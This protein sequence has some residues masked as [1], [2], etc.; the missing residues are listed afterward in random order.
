MCL[1]YNSVNLALS[2]AEKGKTWG[3][4]G[5]TFSDIS[6]STKTPSPKEVGLHINNV[7]RPISKQ[8]CIAE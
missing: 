8:A 4:K 1:L 7:C 6:L 2:V 5:V 3:R